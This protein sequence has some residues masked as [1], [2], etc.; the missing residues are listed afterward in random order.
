MF[1]ITYQI[2]NDV[3]IAEDLTMESFEKAFKNIK[4]FVPR[5]KLITW[6]VKIGRNH[7]LDYRRANNKK[8]K[9]IELDYTIPEYRTPEDELISAEQ[10]II[11]NKA[12][13]NLKGVFKEITT[14]RMDGN[15][16]QDI[17]EKLDIPIGTVQGNLHRIRTKMLKDLH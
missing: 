15:S 16:Y 8:P 12:V 2:V 6:I 3:T 7:A 4:K 13:E 14:L 11:I 9:F 5:Y 17:A 10:T 1:Y